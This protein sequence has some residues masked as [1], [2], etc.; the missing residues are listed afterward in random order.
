MGLV[1][2]Y[3]SLG[4]VHSRC[5]AAESYILAKAAGNC[6]PN[7]EY[8]GAEPYCAARVKIKPIGTVFT[9]AK[10]NEDRLLRSRSPQILNGC[11]SM[12]TLIW[13]NDRLSPEPIQH[14]T[15]PAVLR[16]GYCKGNPSFFHLSLHAEFARLLVAIVEN[17]IEHNP[18]VEVRYR[19]GF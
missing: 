10:M 17:D 19:L 4:L 13:I 16:C 1:A 18:G 6:T 12:L 8:F 5:P 3:G 7:G 2:L 15:H 11:A 9:P 14:P